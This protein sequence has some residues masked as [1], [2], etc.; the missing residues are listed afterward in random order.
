MRLIWWFATVAAVSLVSIV[1]SE[2]RALDPAE[3]LTLT[4]SAP[5]QGVLLDAAGPIQDIYDGIADRGELARENERLRE[6]VE[7]LKAQLAG[8]QD[9]D[10]RIAELEAA[11]GVKQSRPE[12][13][14]LA[15]NVIAEEPSALKSMIAIDRG[16]G[17]GLDEGMVVLSRSGSLVG[18]VA[19]AYEGYAW[20]RLITDPGSAVNA[21]VNVDAQ[22]PQ[23]A[24]SPGVI[25][26]DTPVGQ[27]SPT[28]GASPPAQAATTVR[29]V[30]EGDLHARVTLNLLPPD[31]AIRQG[32]LVVTSGLGGNYPPGILIGSIGEVEDRPQS[33]FKK[34]SV[35][36]ASELSS[37]ETVLVLISFK[38]ARLEAP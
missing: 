13:Q 26:G 35:D 3:N 21:Q 10:A 20:I 32:S 14:L 19:H 18:T 25:T 27:A 23:P 11:L 15:A 22:Q 12:D 9:A 17:D 6:E 28:E 7:A 34:A 38:P 36:P 2:S 24:A 33:A 8:Q 30:A 16:I 31:A 4:A 29:G 1:L 5:L 37:L